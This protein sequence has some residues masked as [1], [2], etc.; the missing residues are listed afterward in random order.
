MRPDAGLQWCYATVTCDRDTGWSEYSGLV[1]SK[2]WKFSVSY[3]GVECFRWD[4]G[5]IP[6]FPSSSSLLDRRGNVVA[7]Q[8]SGGPLYC[9]ATFNQIESAHLSGQATDAGIDLDDG[10]FAPAYHLD[11]S[12]PECAAWDEN[13]LPVRPPCD[14]IDGGV[15]P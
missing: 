15:C 1:A 12:R 3:E 14:V 10:N 11:R 4:S 2:S 13:G 9:G 7:A 5:G 6:G 8:L